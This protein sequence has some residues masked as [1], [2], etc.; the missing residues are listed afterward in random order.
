VTTPVPFSGHTRKRQTRRSV[1]L[2]DKVA[3]FLITCGGMGTICA[4][5]TICGFL[6]WVAAPLFLPA[7]AKALSPVNIR[8][9]D[10]VVAAVASPNG[11]CLGVIDKVGDV[12]AVDLNSGEV[13]SRQKLASDKEP[14]AM[15]FSLDRSVA[16]LGFEDGNV[17]TASFQFTSQT[18]SPLE[19]KLSE[20]TELSPG[21]AVQ[22]IDRAPRDGGEVFAAL[23]A[24][25]KLRVRS[26]ER[27]EN[28]LTGDI[29]T[30][31]TGGD[32]DLSEE[33]Q[34]HWPR[35]LMLSGYGDYAYLV[36]KEGRAVRI[37]CRNINKPTIIESADFLADAPGEIT[38]LAWAQGQTTLLAGDATGSV[39]G[40][41][42]ARVKED[43]AEDGR[44]LVCAHVLEGSKQPVSSLTCSIRKRIVAVGYGDG[45]LRTFYLTNGRSLTSASDGTGGACEQVLISPKDDQ[46]IKLGANSVARWEVNFRYPE[47]T[48][49]SL[50]MPVWYE[51]YAK[52]ERIWQSSGGSD[53]VEPKL[54]LAPLVFGTLKATFYSM[55]FGVPIAILA[56]IYSSEFLHPKAKQIIKPGI[57][58]MASLPSVVL[59]FL[60]GLVV[61]PFVEPRL[62]EV[63]LS[64][65][66]VPFVMIL[67]SLLWQWL[68]DRVTQHRHWFRSVLLVAAFPIGIRLAQALGPYVENRFFAGSIKQW[69]SGGPGGAVAGWVMLLLPLAAVAVALFIWRIVNPV[70]RDA[71]HQ[72]SHFQWGAA[73]ISKFMV[74]TVLA[75][76]LAILVG[77][78]LAWFG[79]DPRGNLI[80][81]YMQRNALIV[82][83]V[84]G[85]AVVPIIYS[86]AEDSLSSVSQHLR[87]ASLAAGATRWQTAYYV[88][89]PTAMSGLFSAVMI[90]LG[91]A[92]GETMIVL[93]A[94]G[95]T[96]IV[97][98]NIFNGF[99][100]L[101]AL[102]A[103]EMPESVVG[104]THYRTLFL[105]ALCL[106]TVTFILNGLAESVR[107]RYRKRAYEL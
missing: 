3:G 68:P 84:M 21:Q 9:V 55:L 54:S 71:G 61:A 98:F 60:G 81:N 83:F 14:S 11:N 69:L 80:G 94:A 6:L 30:E 46:L 64:I 10:D 45:S 78:G 87:A 85:F 5:A 35:W 91:R 92:V 25:K 58:L 28:L 49:A 79:W 24:D 51:G 86:I 57:E 7:H 18:K 44:K 73:E 13:L 38:C 62:A 102:V 101:S 77:N 104:S 29:R 97:D 75:L 72:W 106:F 59:G 103:T 19:V 100:T 65:L 39:R 53:D 36:W 15:A 89:V 43:G 63:L 31:L 82:G 74:G 50:F 96:P 1:I 27:V 48:P 40:W 32:L 88:V 99:Q 105:A 90:G 33:I 2:A 34:D 67:T 107:A 52:P 41:F 4:V 12:R 8:H 26:A 23:C 37:V 42:P 20:P 93:M 47:V 56:A 76:C 17:R 22:L 66:L 95:N 70:L 16:T